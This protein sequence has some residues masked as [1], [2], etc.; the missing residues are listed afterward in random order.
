MFKNVS[1][2]LIMHH[3]KELIKKS[4]DGVQNKNM[5]MMKNNGIVN[6]NRSTFFLLEL[7]FFWF[8]LWK[9]EVN[10]DLNSERQNKTEKNKR[11]EKKKKRGCEI[12][13]IGQIEMGVVGIAMEFCIVFT[14]DIAMEEEKNYGKG[15]MT[16]P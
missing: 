2:M 8:S 11:K 6:K 5:K 7:H 15:P 10:Q 13:V 14:E 3:F 4:K 9:L 1:I 16:Q 12:S